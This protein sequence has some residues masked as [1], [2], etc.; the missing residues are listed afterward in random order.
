MIVPESER[1]MSNSQN[2]TTE[3]VKSGDSSLVNLTRLSWHQPLAAS[4]RL[5]LADPEIVPTVLTDADRVD[6]DQADVAAFFEQFDRAVNVGTEDGCSL[7]TVWCRSIYRA[8]GR[9]KI[10]YSIL[11][12]DIVRKH[13][14]LVQQLLSRMASRSRGGAVFS[15]LMTELGWQVKHICILLEVSRPTVNKWVSRH[16]DSEL[17]TEESRLLRELFSDSGAGLPLDVRTLEMRT[18]RSGLTWRK[19]LLL[20]PP[21]IIK[22]MAALWRVC[23]HMRGT[24][25]TYE[26]K[27]CAY[28]LDLMLDLL[29][30]RGMTVLN[31]AICLDV[32]HRAVFARLGRSAV[33][34]FRGSSWAASEDAAV[35]TAPERILFDLIDGTA[36]DEEAMQRLRRDSGTDECDD[37]DPRSILVKIRTHKASADNPTPVVSFYVLS[38]PDY[39]AIG[40]RGVSRLYDLDFVFSGDVG[41]LLSQYAQGKFTPLI[42]SHPLDDD[43]RKAMLH[44]VHEIASMGPLDGD[45]VPAQLFGVENYAL[46]PAHRRNGVVYT[47]ALLMEAAGDYDRG[48]GFGTTTYHWLPVEMLDKLVHLGLRENYIVEVDAVRTEEQKSSQFYVDALHDFLPPSISEAVQRW[49]RHRSDMSTYK[50]R[51]AAFEENSL[52]WMCLHRPQVV[53]ENYT[54]PKSFEDKADDDV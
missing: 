18:R 16:I 31:I 42:M 46:S 23:Y 10:F 6:Y 39:G 35:W 15:V 37:S 50:H 13:R 12:H 2:P 34:G 52:L 25:S 11:A 51:P 40:P 17:T 33:V 38:S 21:G 4:V 20:P 47:E 5:F 27:V 43:E 3:S 19:G 30:R 1:L 45:T 26:E 22:I 7:E 28:L 36:R 53:L 54:A 41:V 32:T 9:S 44:L 49:L 48:D 29:V 8:K 14:N 24:K